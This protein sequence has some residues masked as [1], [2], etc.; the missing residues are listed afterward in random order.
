MESIPRPVLIHSIGC[1]SFLRPTVELSWSLKLKGLNADA[2]FEFAKRK[3]QESYQHH[4]NDEKEP[5]RAASIGEEIRFYVCL[6]STVPL[7]F[8]WEDKTRQ[9]DHYSNGFTSNKR[10]IN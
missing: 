3:L 10:L 6:A 7:K 4:E 8:I 9:R 5:W 2:K 1:V